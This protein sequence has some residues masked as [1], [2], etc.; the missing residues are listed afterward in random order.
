MDKIGHER[1][2]LDEQ[3]LQLRL[4]KSGGPPD[5][6]RGSVGRYY[7]FIIILRYFFLLTSA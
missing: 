2:S 1:H 5:P 3:V 4:H 7:S 6:F